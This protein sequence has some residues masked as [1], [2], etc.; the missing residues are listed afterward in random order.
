MTST[1]FV[2][3]STIIQADWLMTQYTPNNIL[4]LE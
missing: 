3:K 4:L 1:V 2:D